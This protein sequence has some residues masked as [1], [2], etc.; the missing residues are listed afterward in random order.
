VV[1]NRDKAL[2]LGANGFHSKPVDRIWLL[3][4]LETLSPAQAK[5]RVL[6]IDDDPT[7]RYLIEN[8]LSNIDCELLEAT[9]GAEG[10]R[11][12]QECKPALVVLDLSMPDMSGF[13]VLKSLQ[14]DSSTSKLPVVVHTSMSLEEE[15]YARLSAAVDVIPKSIMGSRELAISRFSQAFQKAGVSYVALTSE[16][17]PTR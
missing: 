13:E 5:P 15:D 4:Q 2:S 6:V 9:G 17:V 12:A 11:M 14:E 3:N 7:S 1:D 16:S 8:L 10:L